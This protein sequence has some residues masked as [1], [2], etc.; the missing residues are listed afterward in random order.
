MLAESN[1]KRCKS[2]DKK[3]LAIT[4][5]QSSEMEEETKEIAKLTL[6]KTDDATSIE[7]SKEEEPSVETSK[8]LQFLQAFE[9]LRELTENDVDEA[10]QLINKYGK[11]FNAF[12]VFILL[13]QIS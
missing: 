7:K 3:L 10:V 1:M 2:D 12:L 5:E 11:I 6:A 8:V 9:R 4:D 13:N